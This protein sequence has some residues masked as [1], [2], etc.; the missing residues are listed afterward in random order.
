MNTKPGNK[1]RLED[2]IDI[3]LFQDL[4]DRLNEIYSFPSSIIDNDGNIL[5]ATGW[6]D[7][8]TK[9]HRQNSECEKACIQ[10]DKYIKEHLDQANP[11]VTYKCPHGLVDNAAPIIIDGVHYGNFFTGQFFMEEPDLDFFRKQAG[12]YGFSED[13]Y[14]EAVK[15]VPIW[16]WEQLNSY[17]FFIKGLIAI[18]SESGLKNLRDAESKK[19]IQKSENRYKSILQTAIDGFWLLDMQGNLLEVNDA[20]CRMSGYSRQELLKMKITDLEANESLEDISKN[21]AEIRNKREDRFRRKHIRRDGRLLEVEVS[22]QYQPELEDHFFCFIRDIT[23]QTQAEKALKES[24]EKYRNLFESMRDAYAS[25]DVK[26]N[27]IDANK[28]F[29][30]MLGY[31]AEELNK[32]TYRDITP[33]KWYSFELDIL[34]KQVLYR[35]YSDTYEKEY[36]HKNG[37]IF[38]VELRTFLLKDKKG[39]GKGM[40]A[41]VRDISERR[42]SE[43]ALREREELL[44]KS[45]EMASIGSFV[46]DMVTNKVTWSH[47]LYK[48]YGYDEESFTGNILEVS[49]K[50]MHPDDAD[51]TSKEVYEMIEKTSSWDVEFRIIRPDGEEKI[52]R[53]KGEVELDSDEKQIKSFGINQDITE[54]KKAEES[55]KKSEEKHRT[56][57]Q[58][59]IDGFLL[60]DKDGNIIEVNDAYCKMSGYT[61]EELINKNAAI[62]EAVEPSEEITREINNVVDKKTYRFIRRHKRKDGLLID[63]EISAQYQPEDGGF[64]CFIRDISRIKEMES[65]LQQAQKMESIGTLAGG[66][67]HDFNNILS[68]IMMHAEMAMEDLPPNDPLQHCMKDIFNAGE[69]ARDLVKQILT[70]ARKRSEKRV[71]LK[72]S[73]IIREALKFLR[74]T[75]PTTINIQYEIMAKRDTVLADA[76]QLNQIIVNLCTNAAHAM[77]E[78]GG[79]LEV[80]LDN[81]EISFSRANRFLNLKPGKYL[82]LSVRDNGTGISSEIIDRIFEPYFTTKK[83][84]EGTGLGLATVH[85]IVRNY[86]GDITVETAAGQGTAFY[87]YLPLVDEDIYDVDEEGKPAPQ[88]GSERIL[89]VD[90]EKAAVVIT[91]K[92]LERFGYKVTSKTSSPD[93]LEAFRNNPDSFDLLITDM[94][95]PNITGEALAREIMAI[96]PDIPVILCTGYSDK[97]NEEKAKKLGIRAFVM[98]PIVMNELVQI[99]REVLDRDMEAGRPGPEKG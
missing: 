19:E 7:I 9:F 70:F 5:T 42:K 31:T 17:L 16:T 34:E 14:L 74:S 88:K 28:A 71:P 97:I 60:M 98:K 1:Y 89:L 52:I 36:I 46:W 65:Q 20:Y 49:A 83:F 55:L 62:L 50:L 56:I 11:A 38:P 35:G 68:P 3:S 45:Q 61:R 54:R 79:Q 2:L 12:K 95:M 44:N 40:W 23:E 41:I 73:R 4:Q 90:D 43:E 48:I 53:S 92:M 81:E 30:E 99:I 78:K 10:S 29:S 91:Q 77:R 13:A 80:T 94:T 67:A 18:I 84:G 25:I 96:N 85:G 58:T 59:A 33:E 63:V 32:L 8:C 93:A 15:K 82:K 76:T 86:G 21:I 57:L 64:V 27:I 69:R 39:A 37:A 87:V 51:R 75:I 66:I 47:N 24:E 22:V 26:G 6:Q 72:L